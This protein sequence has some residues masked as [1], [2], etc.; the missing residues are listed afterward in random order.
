MIISLYF[1]LYLHKLSMIRKIYPILFT[2]EKRNN[3]SIYYFHINV[4][5]YN[6]HSVMHICYYGSYKHYT[7]L[8]VNKIDFNLLFEEWGR[9]E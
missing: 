4:C 9:F 5:T 6:T 8:K 7:Q 1:Q 2:L 3:K